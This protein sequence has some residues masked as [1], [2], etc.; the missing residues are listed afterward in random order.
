MLVFTI[1]GCESREGIS[2]RVARFFLPSRTLVIYFPAASLGSSSQL[3]RSWGNDSVVVTLKEGDRWEPAIGLREFAFT[4]L[5]CADADSVC[6]RFDE[7]N[8]LVVPPEG[9]WFAE[10]P[11]RGSARVLKIGRG[12]VCLV[13]GGYVDAEPRVAVRLRGPNERFN[14]RPRIAN[15]KV[16]G[17]LLW[18]PTGGPVP[19]TLWTGLRTQPLSGIVMAE[20]TKRWAAADSNGYFELDSLPQGPVRLVARVRGIAGGSAVAMAPGVFVTIRLLRDP[21]EGPSLSLIHI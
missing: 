3:V 9:P 10:D 13:A 12:P 8:V 2:R 11:L 1:L 18:G 6:I 7:R 19:R 14:T 5:P 17:R 4:I 15:G 20:W 16:T 21:I